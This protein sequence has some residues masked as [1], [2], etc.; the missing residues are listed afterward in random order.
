MGL[1]SVDPTVVDYLLPPHSR[2]RRIPLVEGL[3]RPAAARRHPAALGDGYPSRPRPEGFRSRIAC[4]AS[5]PGNP[6]L[7]TQRSIRRPTAARHPADPGGAASCRSGKPPYS[8]PHS[9]G[10]APEPF[11]ETAGPTTRAQKALIIQCKVMSGR[12]D[13]NL[14]P[15]DPQSSALAR[16]RHAPKYSRH[17][18]G[19][20]LHGPRPPH[21]CI[22]SP[23]LQHELPSP[24]LLPLLPTMQRLQ[25]IAKRVPL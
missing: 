22:T 21:Y 23:A 25:L 3:D 12:Q 5:R 24:L 10:I 16:L 1:M 6:R 9:P 11:W 2:R 20:R 13:L 4:P 8:A 18:E 14:R 15:L 19:S 17:R 7:A